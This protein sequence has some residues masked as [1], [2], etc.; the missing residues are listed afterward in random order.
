MQIHLPNQSR[1]WVKCTHWFVFCHDTKCHEQQSSNTNDFHMRDDNISLISSAMIWTSSSPNTTSNQSP[2]SSLVPQS[3]TVYSIVSPVVWS[4]KRIVRPIRFGPTP[5]EVAWGS[6]VVC[7]FNFTYA[8]MLKEKI[9]SKMNE[10]SDAHYKESHRR[11]TQKL[12]SSF[13]HL[14]S[15]WHASELLVLYDLY[16]GPACKC[17]L[18]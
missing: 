9:R 2:W 16:T 13:H 7:R 18:A 15:V 5:W 6:T 12:L 10:Q 11:D 3:W 4:G 8:S 17:D 1:H 14:F